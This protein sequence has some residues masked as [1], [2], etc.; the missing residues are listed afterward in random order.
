MSLEL[1]PK[2]L[3]KSYGWS[4]K[5]IRRKAIEL[6][7]QLNSGEIII[8]SYN[9]FIEA[10]IAVELS[11]ILHVPSVISIHG[12]YDSGRILENP[13]KNFLYRPFYFKLFKS[14]FRQASVCVGVYPEASNFASRL[15][16]SKTL[17]IYNSVAFPPNQIFRPASKIKS[18]LWNLIWINR[19]IPGKNPVNIIRSLTY[20]PMA[21]LTIIGTGSLQEK[22]S[23]VIDR[24]QLEKE[25][26]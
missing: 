17:T 2:L 10:A 13:F 11:N 5:F 18:E 26:V 23:K 21:K 12:T 9:C 24:H 16:A 7:K 22:I 20:I 19:L 4:K 15:G 1:P 6:S 14:I 25:L 3:L 8:R